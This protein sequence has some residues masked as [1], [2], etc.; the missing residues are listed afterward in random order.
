MQKIRKI[1]LCDQLIEVIL[2]NIND[3][4]WPQGSQL[5]NEIDLARS[6]DVSRNIMREALKI[7]ENFGVLNV[8]N[9]V[10]TF[11]SERANENIENMHFYYSLRD[12]AS[13]EVL[14]EL[15]L[16]LEPSAAYYAALRIDE[17]GISE[18]K[19]ISD[20]VLDKNMNDPICTN[21]FEIHQAIA[22][23]S[24]N[25]LCEALLTAALKQLENSL[26]N[27]FNA[28]ASPGTIKDNQDTHTAIMDA[29]MDHN[30]ELAKQ[31]MTDHLVRRIKLINPDYES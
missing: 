2:R 31:L 5:Q 18:L 10:G 23:Y 9:G 28:F 15:R 27:E 11:V 6:F 30:A 19:T 8:R 21:D 25:A 26:Y 29:I 20:R 14:L 1:N 22:H 7:L 3:G 13:V 24:G 16:M 12:N 17:K 4:T